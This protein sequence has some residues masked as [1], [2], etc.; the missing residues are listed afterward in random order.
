MVKIIVCP[1]RKKNL[2][3]AF[4]PLLRM[5]QTHVYV[6]SIHTSTYKNTHHVFTTRSSEVG[7]SRF[8]GRR[9]RLEHERVANAIDHVNF[10]QF[11]VGDQ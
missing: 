1:V 9:P 4:S 3:A 11:N 5:F 6:H 10:S 8:R 7:L 2:H